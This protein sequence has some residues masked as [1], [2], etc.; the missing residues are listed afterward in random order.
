MG[1]TRKGVIE[2]LTILTVVG[3]RTT[4]AVSTFLDREGKLDSTKMLK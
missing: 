2:D 3:V 1:V 4:R